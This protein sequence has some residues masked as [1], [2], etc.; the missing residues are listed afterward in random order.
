M[1]T[2]NNI[3]IGARLKKTRLSGQLSQEAFATALNVALRA[4]QNYER[5]E[6]EIP[7]TLIVA[8]HLHFHV[9]PIWLLTGVSRRAGKTG[10]AVKLMEAALDILKSDRFASI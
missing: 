10:K 8:L 3:E 1:N 6:R 7:A 2:L 4:Y 9:D 5:G